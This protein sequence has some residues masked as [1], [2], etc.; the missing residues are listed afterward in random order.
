MEIGQVRER[1]ER[2]AL[3][4]REME[5]QHRLGGRISLITSL[6]DIMQ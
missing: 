5:A 2:R 3:M 4:M 6:E 1:K